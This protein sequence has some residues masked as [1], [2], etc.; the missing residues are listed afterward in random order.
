L[1]TAREPWTPLHPL[2]AL[3]ELADAGLTATHIVADTG[4]PSEG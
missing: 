1:P 4:T 3:E 2:K